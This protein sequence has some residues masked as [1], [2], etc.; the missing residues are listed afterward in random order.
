MTLA[1]ACFHLVLHIFFQ[2]NTPNDAFVEE[3]KDELPLPQP[4]MVTLQ[5]YQCFLEQRDLLECILV[6][7]L[8]TVQLDSDLFRKDGVAH[9]DDGFQHSGVE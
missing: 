4:I 7:D 2:D 9:L 3:I 6:P 8:E 5:Q 1:C